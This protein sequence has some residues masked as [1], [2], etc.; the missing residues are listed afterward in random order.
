MR[1]TTDSMEKTLQVQ[2]G[3]IPLNMKP[4]IRLPIP[5]PRGVSNGKY[6]M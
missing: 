4:V 5:L 1:I 2:R 3:P 6:S